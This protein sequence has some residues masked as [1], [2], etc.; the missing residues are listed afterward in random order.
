MRVVVYDRL[1]LVRLLFVFLL[2][3]VVSLIITCRKR[4]N[5]LKFQFLSSFFFF[6]LVSLSLPCGFGCLSV[7]KRAADIGGGY[8]IAGLSTKG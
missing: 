8:G 1:D 7:L 5:H 6:L 3:Q 2:T 4:L